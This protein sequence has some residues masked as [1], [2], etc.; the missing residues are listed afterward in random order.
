[1][2]RMNASLDAERFQS[3][4]DKYAAY[5]DTPEGRL[6]LDLAFANLQEFMP[7]DKGLC[8]HWISGAAPARRLFDWRDLV[9]TSRC[10]IRLRDAGYREARR[11]GSEI[12]RRSR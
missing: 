7:E 12:P 2:K 9:F 3:G 10:W 4:A 1:M 8:V 6:R 5:L 11:T